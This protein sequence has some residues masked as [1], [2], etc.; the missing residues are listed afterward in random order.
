MK[1]ISYDGLYLLMRDV[2]FN[3]YLKI[4]LFILIKIIIKK[5]M[6]L[7]FLN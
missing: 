6:K 5:K 3:H 7:C 4:K 1:L 2:A